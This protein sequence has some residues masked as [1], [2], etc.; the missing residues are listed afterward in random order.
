MGH[1]VTLIKSASP[2]NSLCAVG[3]RAHW[4]MLLLLLLEVFSLITRSRRSPG[5]GSQPFPAELSAEPSTPP[6]SVGTVSSLVVYVLGTVA[7]CQAVST[8]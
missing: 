2:Q 5:G 3:A 1:C 8:R 6:H 7:I 4:W